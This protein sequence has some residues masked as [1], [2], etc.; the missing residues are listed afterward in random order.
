MGQHRRRQYQHHEA[1]DG[2]ARF[3]TKAHH[4][5]SLIHLKLDKEFHQ[6]YPDN[7]NPVKLV[8]R[9]KKIEEDLS[10]L[11]YQCRE[12]LAAK[13]DLIDKARSVL[14]GNRSML[15]CMQTSVGIPIQTDSEGSAYTNFNQIIKEW[16]A[17]VRSRTGE[18]EGQGTESE[19]INKLLFSSIVR[20]T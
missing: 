8:A 7:A 19:D 4:D 3:F 11:K 15:Q 17:Q 13:Q 14:V 2:L 6:I 20:S 9:I 5:L 10:S 18:D 12:L 16:T 1:A